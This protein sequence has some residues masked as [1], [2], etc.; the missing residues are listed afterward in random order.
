MFDE[1]LP[2]LAYSFSSSSTV[3]SGSSLAEPTRSSLGRWRFPVI[4]CALRASSASES[5]S[6]SDSDS[7]TKIPPA[8]DVPLAAAVLEEEAGWFAVRFLFGDVVD[9]A[10]ELAG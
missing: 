2:E 7:S 6:D 5:A 4:V 3:V 9:T 10:E 8:L 1:W